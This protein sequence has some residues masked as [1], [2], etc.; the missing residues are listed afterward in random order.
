[1]AQVIKHLPS[2]HEALSLNSNT[3][4]IKKPQKTKKQMKSK[5]MVMVTG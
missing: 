3:S 4:K 1:V 5:G 2:E